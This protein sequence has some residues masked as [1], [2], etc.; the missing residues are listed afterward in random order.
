MT[1]NDSAEKTD[2]THKENL[3]IS[4]APQTADV[5]PESSSA[6]TIDW[7]GPDDPLNPL[8]WSLSRR[9]TVTA[10]VDMFTYVVTLT[11]G[12]RVRLPI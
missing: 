5:H 2:L 12:T 6:T 10:I 4:S 1:A 7:D 3:T 9:I 8:N 11:V